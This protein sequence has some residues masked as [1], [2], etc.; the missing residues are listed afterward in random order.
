MQILSDYVSY[1]KN[2]VLNVHYQKD[3]TLCRPSVIAEGPLCLSAV[4][5]GK[6]QLQLCCPCFSKGHAG[7][8]NF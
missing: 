1:V 7:K 3:L 5:P 8:Y 6:T 2:D 4:E